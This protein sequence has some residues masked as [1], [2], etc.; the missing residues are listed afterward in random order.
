MDT[1]V[2]PLLDCTLHNGFQA[3]AAADTVLPNPASKSIVVL[4]HVMVHMKRRGA[5]QDTSEL[6]Q[7]SYPQD[8]ELLVEGDG[9]PV[10]LRLR[11]LQLVDLRL[12][13]VGQDGVWHTQGGRVVQP[14]RPTHGG[15]E[16]GVVRRGAP[17][18]LGVRLGAPRRPEGAAM[19]VL[20]RV[21][22][23]VCTC[24]HVCARVR[25]RMRA[26]ACVRRG[27]GAPSIGLG[28]CERSQMSAWLSSPAVLMWHDECGAHA[29]ELTHW[30]W[31][32]SFAAGS[33]GTRMSRITTQFE[34]IVITAK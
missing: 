26:R 32:C 5:A 29:S 19:D 25:V 13:G 12:S 17:R 30:E 11:P 3:R 8:L 16:G 1:L 33:E 20:A 18:C 34:S 21:C 31:P 28:M 23:R 6:G 4:T 10:G 22:A 24:V 9:D 14:A 2:T 15:R 27:R 7:W